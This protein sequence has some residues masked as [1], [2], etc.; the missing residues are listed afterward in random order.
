MSMRSRIESRG[1][2]VSN[3]KYAVRRTIFVE[4]PLSF[5]LPVPLCSE[6]SRRI[7]YNILCYRENNDIGTCRL[8]MKLFM[9]VGSILQSEIKVTRQVYFTPD[10]FALANAIPS[11]AYVSTESYGKEIVSRKK[12]YHVSLKI[13]G[14][15]RHVRAEY[16]VVQHRREYIVQ[17][18]FATRRVAR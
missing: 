9:K 12:K 5:S 8:F 1:A 13:S 15:M 7:L 18:F 17:A 4:Q 16:N 14:K 6:I 11:F 2:K 3:Y 10:T